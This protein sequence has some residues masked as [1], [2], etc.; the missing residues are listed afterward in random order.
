[1]RAESRLSNRRQLIIRAIVSEYIVS[2]SPVS[3]EHIVRKYRLDASPATV[4][5]D[6]MAL[7]EEGY[8]QRPHT[9]A[10][11]VPLERA[12]RLY[13]ESL[14]E[15]RE[16]PAQ[17]QILI[18]H[19][20]H[21][22][23]MHLDEWTRLAAAVLSRI[24]RNAALVT[25]PKPP[26]CRFKHMEL[27]SVQDFLALLVLVLKEARL[28][29]QLLSLGAA[30]TQEEMSVTANR[31]NAL[32]GSLSAAEIEKAKAESSPLEQQVSR[33]V[34]QMMQLDDRQGYEEIYLD[35]LRHVLSQPEFVGQTRWQ[36]LL[37][38]LEER[39]LL[40]TVLPDLAQGQGVTVL[41]GDENREESIRDCSLVVS[42]Y[43]LPG[44]MS[45]VLGVLGPMRMRYDYTIATVRY[46]ATLMSALVGELYGRA[47][48]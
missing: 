28:K 11:A 45:G 12:Y 43:G 48:N 7:E 4:R 42:R 46:M 26:E 37:E 39:S 19:L 41:I 5:N 38:I 40:K 1:M 34:V 10:G 13:V 21:Q 2:A 25:V 22:V 6:M 3:S 8:I 20:F 16:L 23:E 33:S 27:I 15:A 29:Q 17:E 14:R 47:R 44:E 9:S 35:G 32:Y 31:L 36:G 30:S 18:Q 24:A